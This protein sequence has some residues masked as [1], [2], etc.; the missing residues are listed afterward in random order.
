MYYY[1]KKKVCLPQCCRHW[2]VP[3]LMVHA[4]LRAQFKALIRTTLEPGSVQDYVKGTVRVGLSKAQ[5][6]DPLIFLFKAV[7]LFLEC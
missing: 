3:T 7:S 1:I 5:L 2:I 4:Q 6:R